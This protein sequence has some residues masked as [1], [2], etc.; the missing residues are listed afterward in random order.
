M[1]NG[2]SKGI[3]FVEYAK[4]SDAAKALEESNGIDLHGRTISVEYSGQKPGGDGA[5]GG[6][7]SGQAGAATTVFCGNI[8]FYT[9]EQT[10]RD[11]FGRAGTVNQV[12]IAMGEDGRARGFC[13]IE[14]A[15]PAHA[16]AAMKFNGQEID[17]RAIRLDLSA[18]RQG[19]GGRGGFGG[20]RG[21]FGG[22]RG[23]RGGFGGGRGGFGD[24]GGRGGFGDRG[25]GGFGGRG[26]GRGGFG[27]RGRGG[28][29][30]AQKGSIQPY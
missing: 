1:S 8:G 22:D 19:G 5:Q 25:R 6:R 21:G 16:E 3:A 28:F 27:D 23:G 20:G 17:G 2:Q 11:F 15:D 4:S 30:P 29:N 10:I 12:R 13:H 18:P 7:P 14:F 9:E 26:G 24:R